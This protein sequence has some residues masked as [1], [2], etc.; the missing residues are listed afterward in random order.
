MPVQKISDCLSNKPYPQN[1]TI[2]NTFPKE[3]TDE[4]RAELEKM[5][6]VDIERLLSRIEELEDP[7]EPA[8]KACIFDEIPL[9][10][11][12][13]SDIFIVVREK[14]NGSW[15]IEAALATV[16]MAT[17]RTEEGFMDVQKTYLSGRETLPTVDQIA[18]DVRALVRYEEMVE[19]FFLK[20][21][22][23]AHLAR[24]G[25]QNAKEMLR[26]VRQ[27]DDLFYLDT[28]D[29]IGGDG[30]NAIDSVHF[31]F[32]IMADSQQET[33]QLFIIKAFLDTESPNAAAIKEETATAFYPLNG[34]FPRKDTMIEEV[35]SK[36]S[37]GKGQ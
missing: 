15:Y 5:Q 8:V 11:T 31:Q 3:R 30:P 35:L 18:Q 10:D 28:T 7:N 37:P 17:T 9:S 23:D 13:M 24:I 16:Q 32:V 34:Q 25:F 2:M 21:D 27:S 19:F 12:A 14:E 33:A 6:F 26:S 29:K 20:N 4:I 36:L 22:L 1:A